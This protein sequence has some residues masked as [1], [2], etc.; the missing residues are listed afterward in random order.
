VW[1]GDSFDPLTFAFLRFT[2][3]AGAFFPFLRKALKDK[4]I[5]K[6]GLE[7]GVWSALGY[8]SQSLGL[9]TT[10]ASRASFISAFTVCCC[11]VPCKGW[12]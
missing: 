3:A 7:L 11:L 9:M 12:G 2:I 1:T 8:L 10:D 4:K 6:A 5:V